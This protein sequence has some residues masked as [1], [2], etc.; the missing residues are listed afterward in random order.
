LKTR[1]FIGCL[2]ASLAAAQEIV[3]SRS[4]RVAVL[5]DKRINESSGLALSPRD[6][7]IFWTHNDSASEPCVYAINRLGKTL[8]KVRLPHSV[9]FDWED[10][11]SARNAEGQPLLFIG[12]IG[13]NLKVRPS[14]QIYQ[15]PEPTLPATAEKEIASAEPIIWHASYPD[16][17]HNAETLLVHPTTQRLY[18]VTKTEDGNC[19]LYAFPETLT[20]DKP[21]VLEK[22]TDLVFPPRAHLGKRPHDACQTVSGCFSPDG[23]RLA[24][25]TYSFIHEWKIQPGQSLKEALK[26][27]PRLIEPPVTS[28]MEAICY[29]LDGETLWFTSE[30]LPTPLFRLTR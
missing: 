23:R 2:L 19:A 17:R 6:P 20:A 7:Q 1:L 30:R 11:A 10:M 28:Q 3:P 24:I 9:N 13:D 12:D 4:E 21:M 27:Q 22:I 15:I 18:V 25:A 29:D 14:L 16:G 26:K 8:A 5:E